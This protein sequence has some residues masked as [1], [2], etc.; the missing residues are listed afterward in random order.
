MRSVQATGRRPRTDDMPA[1]P[2]TS[3][4][5]LRSVKR[6]DGRRV[7]ITL[8]G[9][10]PSAD[11]PT[12]TAC[13]RGKRSEVPRYRRGIARAIDGH[14]LASLWSVARSHRDHRPGA[15]P[16]NDRW[17]PDALRMEMDEC[18]TSKAQIYRRRDAGRHLHGHIGDGME[19][20]EIAFHETRKS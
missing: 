14:C 4:V 7:F 13:N 11:T 12:T 20:R 6:E 8:H 9:R 3:V 10:F 15:V 1:G 18:S 5:Q 2:V 16:M 17:F 19:Q